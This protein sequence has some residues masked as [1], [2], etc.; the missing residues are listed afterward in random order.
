MDKIEASPL[1]ERRVAGVM[2]RLQ[3][4]LGERYRVEHEIGSGGM[5]TVYLA[6]DLKHG[7]EVAIKLLRPELV[8]G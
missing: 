5:S 7:R 1:T 4:V 2:D 3:E 6:R 8:A